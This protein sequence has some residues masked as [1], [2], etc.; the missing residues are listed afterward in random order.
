MAIIWFPPEVSPNI[1]KTHSVVP[2][3]RIQSLVLFMFVANV[4]LMTALNCD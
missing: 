2:T 4:S 3:I 1:V